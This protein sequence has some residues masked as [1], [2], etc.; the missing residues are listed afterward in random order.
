M[1]YG[2][3]MVIHKIAGLAIKLGKLVY[4][5][6]EHSAAATTIL[7]DMVTNVQLFY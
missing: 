7:I 6:F 2:K 5:S 3:P 1:L 4:L